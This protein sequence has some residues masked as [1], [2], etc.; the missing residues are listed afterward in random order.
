VVSSKG[1]ERSGSGQKGVVR[2]PQAR[3]G[4][5]EVQNTVEQ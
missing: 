4:V 5:A 3:R 2:R 1:W